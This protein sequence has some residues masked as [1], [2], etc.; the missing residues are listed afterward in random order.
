MLIGV[1]TLGF[2]LFGQSARA[3]G[4]TY[5]WKDATN[6]AVTASGGSY[7]VPVIFTKTGTPA[8][9]GAE[10]TGNSQL[11]CP[12]GTVVSML[13]LSVNADN[14]TKIY[15]SLANLTIPPAG[16]CAN[17]DSPIAISNSN[18]LTTT[19]SDAATA[20]ATGQNTAG[21]CD[22]GGFSWLFC[23]V[24]DNVSGTINKLVKSALVPLLEVKPISAQSTPELHQV[25]AHVRDF[26]E[27]LFILVFLIIIYSTITEQDLG[28]F[29]KYNVKRMLPRLVAAA[30]LV[31]FSFSISSLIVDLGNV[32]GGGIETFILSTLNPTSGAPSL[33][34]ALGNMITGS[35]AVLVGA[36]AIAILATWTIALPLLLSL[37]VSVFIV[38]LTLGARFLLIA[39]LIAISPL[40]MLAWV[41]PNTESYFTAWRK[42]FLSLIL[43]YPIIVG[44]LSIASIVSEILPFTSSTAVTAPAAVAVAIIQPL[45]AIAAFLMVPVTF[46]W[47]SKGLS[48]FTGLL[49]SAGSR[50]QGLLKGSEFW[51]RG[52]EGRKA[53]QADYMNRVVKSDA[54]TSL[55]KGNALSRGAGK[56]AT[57][58][59]GVAFLNA[60]KTAR[61]TE[62]LRSGIIASTAKT[63]EGLDEATIPNLQKVWTAFYENDPAKRK[64]ARRELQIAAPN[65]MQLASTPVGRVAVQKRL[66]E[67]GFTND[68]PIN[69]LKASSRN[70]FGI[71][72]NMPLEYPDMLRAGGKEFGAKPT[73]FARIAKATDKYEIRDALGNVVAIKHRNVGDVDTNVLGGLIRGITSSGF[74]DK[75]GIDNFKQMGK[76]GDLDTQKDQ[77]A[78]E[79]AKEYAKNLEANVV[80]RVFDPGHKDFGSRG[81]RYEWLKNIEKNRDV[82]ATENPRIYESSMKSFERDEDIT[83]D[84]CK[85]A[86]IDESKIKA[87][88]TKGKAN[89]ARDW[90]RGTLYDSSHDYE[91][92]GKSIPLI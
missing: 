26:T 41:L 15:P 4:E 24:I 91:L 19:Q 25:W 13:K 80:E 70:G 1:I 12:A 77:A 49:N 46:S 37:L 54:I 8:S 33:T 59:A 6:Q 89:A 35:L 67:M 82:F 28:G 40:A 21:T 10:F 74:G 45:I 88:S 44:V 14:Y 36:G 55:G 47:A 87:L 51:Q 38:F 78:E 23:P 48:R 53:R 22:Q 16:A 64:Q 3:A 72:G 31:Q 61:G 43:M 18:G 58:G 32:L 85:L 5:S 7:K 27:I 81:V 11:S 39:I 92:G 29:N 76:R 73:I 42:L 66:A 84:I 83:S 69:S 75:H 52:A 86:G 17:L 65:L 60:P 68:A 71:N 79:I 9:G 20:A 62:K 90:M 57:F 34:N 30:I 56:A 2:G 63:L 50:G